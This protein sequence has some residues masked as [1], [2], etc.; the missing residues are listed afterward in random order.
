VFLW[1]KTTRAETGVV[2]K[3]LAPRHHWGPQGIRNGV[4]RALDEP[5]MGQNLA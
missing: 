1:V 3:L 2:L 4:L 5:G